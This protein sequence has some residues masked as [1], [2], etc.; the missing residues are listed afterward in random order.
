M[1]WLSLL[2]PAAF[3]L[4]LRLLRVGDFH[5]HKA[6]VYLLVAG[7]WVLLLAARR[8]PRLEPA[9]RSAL[10]RWSALD[11][12]VAI[13]VWAAAFWTI[14]PALAVLALLLVRGGR[15]ER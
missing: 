11:P 8:V 10:R 7:A 15:R 5:H 14:V 13:L 2:A 1:P 4:A 3:T 12:A 9:A 6:Q